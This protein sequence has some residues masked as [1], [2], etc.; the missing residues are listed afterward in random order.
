MGYPKLLFDN[1]FGDGTVVASGTAAGNYAAANI[2]DMRPYTWWKAPSL[3]SS[4]TVDSGAVQPGNYALVYGHDLLT[5]GATVEVRASTD[6]FAA[7]NVL[8]ATVTPASNDPFLVEFATANYRY[9]R[10]NFTGTAVNTP[11]IAIAMIGN[12][13]VMPKFLSAGDFDPIGRALSQQSNNNDNGYPLG[14]IIDFEKFTQTLQFANVS[15]SWLRSAWQPAW[16]SNLRGSPFIFAW[17]S[18]NYPAEIYLVNAGDNYQSPH[19]QG[20]LAT[21]QFDVS[22]VAK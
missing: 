15:W 2:T 19:A 6:N 20:G 22:G 21:L 17:D 1:L 13:F 16:R 11:S 9:W 12:A 4:L 14:K 18:V 8:L 5:R 10:L 3:P 7:S